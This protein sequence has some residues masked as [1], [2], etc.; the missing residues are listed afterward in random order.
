MTR[1]SGSLQ[2]ISIGHIARC[3]EALTMVKPARLVVISFLVAA[4]VAAGGASMAQTNIY[5]AMSAGFLA[6]C[7]AAAGISGA[8]VLLMD[9]VREIEPRGM[10]DAWVFGL[11]CLV[12]A[13]LLGL[14]YILIFIAITIVAVIVFFVCK[15]P[16]VGPFLLA[17]TFP[18]FA[19]VYGV[20]IFSMFVVIPL[21]MSA[22]WEGR[23]VIET[24]GVIIALIKERLIMAVL[25][26]MLLYVIWVVVA[27]VI[28][29]VVLWGIASTLSV[30]VPVIGYEQLATGFANL[31]GA[32]MAARFSGGGGYFIALSVDIAAMVIVVLAALSQVWIMGINL[33]Y[34]SAVN[35]LDTAGAQQALQDG[36]EKTKQKAEEMK[37]HAQETTERAR[38][39]VESARAR[40]ATAAAPVAKPSAASGMSHCPAC[41]GITKPTDVFCGHCGHKLR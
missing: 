16:G 40:S 23:S 24:L 4:V 7:V 20:M 15:T 9:R 38:Q 32:L 25:S 29:A 5:I 1:L 33:V 10:L 34:L 12:K 28:A 31:L 37:R 14:I 2:Q 21:T 39:A 8:G 22:L 11:M 17:L 27:G 26:L 18:P 13:L 36:L 6:A 3:V 41:N 19:L 35:G 30:A